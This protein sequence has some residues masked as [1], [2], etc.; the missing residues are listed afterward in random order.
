MTPMTPTH[1]RRSWFAVWRWKWW[2]WVAVGLLMLVC[3]QLTCPFLDYAVLLWDVPD[4]LEDVCWH[5]NGPAHWA[6]KRSTLLAS[7]HDWEFKM[8]FWLLRVRLIMP[9]FHDFSFIGNCA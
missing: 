5:I 2:V 9:L 4:W 8:I 3:Y 6:I 7:L 1:P